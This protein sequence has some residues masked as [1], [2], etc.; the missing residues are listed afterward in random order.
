MKHLIF[1]LLA[2]AA[3]LASSCHKPDKGLDDLQLQNK[4]RS[5]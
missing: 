1:M 2:L 3:L 4:P 5:L